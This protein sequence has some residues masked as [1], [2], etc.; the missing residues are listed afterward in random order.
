MRM[1]HTSNRGITLLEVIFSIAIFGLVAVAA[2]EH[3]G[4]SWSFTKMNRER[5][6]AYRKAQSILAELQAF[7]DRGD[8][9][10]AADL[11][12]FDDG[13]SL[14][15][16]LTITE[17]SGNLVEPAHPA[18]LNATTEGGVWKWSRQIS[19]R[20]FPGQQT[21]DVRFVT[22]RIFRRNKDHTRTRLAEMSSVIR[23]IGQSYPTTQVYDVYLLALENIP[24]WWVYMDSI[25]PFV[26]STLTDLQARNPGLTFRTHWI[27]KAGFGRDP[28]YAPY[29]NDKAASNESIPG[30]YFYPGRMPEGSAAARYYV[31]QEIQGVKNMDGELLNTISDSPFPYTLADQFN[32][33]MRLPDAMRLF[34]QRVAVGLDKPEQPTWRLLLED[35]IAHPDKFHNAIFVNLHGELLPMPAMRNYSDPAKDPHSYRGVRVVTHPENLRYDNELGPDVKLRVYAY[36]EP[37]VTTTVSEIDTVTVR[38]KG[39]NLPDATSVVKAMNLGDPNQRPVL[40]EKVELF[41]DAMTKQSKYVRVSFQPSTSEATSKSLGTSMF[42]SSVAKDGDALVLKLRRTSTTCAL[43]SNN[44]GLDS[45]WRLYGR[46]YIPTPLGSGATFAQDLTSTANVPK[47]TARWI[48]TVRRDPTGLKSWLPATAEGNQILEVETFIGDAPGVRYPTL[49]KFDAY[50]PTLL[51]NPRWSDLPTVASEDPDTWDPSS[52]W[53]PETEATKRWPQTKPA[54]VV[55]PSN[56]SR[57]FVYWTKEVDDVPFTERYQFIGDPRHCPYADLKEGGAHFPNGFNWFFDDQYNASG[58]FRG[59]WGFT[60]GRIRD[61]WMGRLEIDVPRFM[62]TLR[63]AITRSEVLYTTLTGWS[64]YYLG[65]GNEIGYDSANGFPS[66][67]PLDGRPYGTSASQVSVDSISGGGD[68]D[69]RYVKLIRQ[70]GTS[71]YWWGAHWLGELYP[72]WAFDSAWEVAGNLPCGWN[73]GE[74][75]RDRRQDVT[76]NL[77]LGT[78]FS[79]GQRVAKR[80]GCTSFFNIGRSDATFHHQGT[81]GQEGTL[82]TTGL[83][84]AGSYNFSLPTRTKISRPFALAA[85]GSGGVGP[86]YNYTTDYPRHSAQLVKKY[87]AHPV[88]GVDGSA[89]VEVRPPNEDRSA[90]VVVNGIDK[91]TESGSAFIS[92]YS[93]LTLIHSLLEAGDGGLKRPVTRLPR[94]V[95]RGPTAVT[96]LGD[97]AEIPV[98]W[99]TLWTRWDGRPYSSSSSS[100]TAETET[101][102]VY[103][104]IYSRDNGKTWRHVIDESPAEPGQMPGPTQVLTDQGSGSERFVWSTPAASYPEGS[105]LLRIE[106]YRNHERLHY[107]HHTEKIYIDRG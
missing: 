98:T 86:E 31:P 51:G 66:S 10:V 59:Y 19:V 55:N 73:L 29:M 38:I 78:S 58:N 4:L 97:P 44:S 62:Q 7:V 64:Y 101:G 76:Y 2:A 8:A 106:V 63:K 87:Y 84:I 48:I 80:E 13:T 52:I 96:E 99:E 95:I 74:F 93:M 72:D 6:F 37:G 39:L 24:G 25:H 42:V 60:S 50:A 102:L 16:A 14:S 88:Y 83:E 77:P 35:M 75:F 67:I 49:A 20:P 82:T 5:I 17:S 85:S 90:Y 22:V 69:Y 30:V 81:D 46:S 26:E 33:C 71:S 104:L 27:T 107:A 41:T 32:H 68:S 54:Y 65:I 12:R 103:A 89:M 92:K 61:G 15:N 45:K 53:Q 70:A 100:N 34:Q 57:T 43:A 105:Y 47:N 79:Y 56:M 18:S 94:A 21:R 36:G 3:I 23:S 40:L 9:E 91:T 1:S 11:D 28:Y